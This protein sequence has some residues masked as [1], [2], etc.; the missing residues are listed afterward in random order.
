MSFLLSLVSCCPKPKEDLGFSA[1]VSVLADCPKPNEDPEAGAPKGEAAEP[2]GL[3]DD[4][5][6]PPKP[7]VEVVE[8]A[9]L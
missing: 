7:N 5:A 2:A 4:A 3:G 6:D 9:E 1:S 8:G